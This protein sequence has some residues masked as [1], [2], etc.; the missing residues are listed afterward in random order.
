MRVLPFILT[1]C[2]AT[3]AQADIADDWAQVQKESVLAWQA[4]TNAFVEVLKEQC[5]SESQ[6]LQKAELMASWRKLAESWGAV[7]SQHPAAI[8]ELGL[9]YRVAFWPDSRGVVAR[10]M[11]THTQE[12]LRGEYQGLSIAGQGIQAVDWM[13]AREQP[14]CQFLMDWSKHYQAYV[15][16]IVEAMP[17]RLQ[18]EDR[19]LTVA[20][21]DLY[22]Q[23]SLLNQR[24]R[25]VIAEKGGRYRPH[26]GDLPQTGESIRFIRGGLG[27]LAGRIAVLTNNLPDDR[28][29][30]RA[31]VL[32]GELLVLADSLPEGWPEQADQAWALSERIR[33]VNRAV[34]QWL[35][36][37]VATTYSILIGFNNQ[38]GD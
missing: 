35:S 1:S 27:D 38:D 32:R 13:L 19:A 28:M 33:Q 22:A 5:R 4:Q 25:E 34:E 17:D 21:N 23:A 16:Q 2:L 30:E 15:S 8:D 37:E 3:L 20:A 26:M 36:K 29:N 24:L 12:R 10:Q 11:E 9:G 31:E 6:I 14:E 18:P 7:A